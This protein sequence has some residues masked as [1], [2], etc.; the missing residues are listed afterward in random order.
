MKCVLVVE[1]IPLV[2]VTVMMACSLVKI[3][4]VQFEFFKD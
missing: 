2:S 4:Q 3:V 1:L